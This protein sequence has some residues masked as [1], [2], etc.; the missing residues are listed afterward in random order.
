VLTV[1]RVSDGTTLFGCAGS[2]GPDAC[3]KA[4]T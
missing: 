1:Y 2:D 3:S 4:P